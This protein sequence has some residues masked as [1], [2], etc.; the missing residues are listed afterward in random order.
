MVPVTSDV[1]RD[2]ALTAF[3]ERTGP[4][5]RRAVVARYGFEVGRDAAA[6]AVA[7]AV[8]NWERLSGMANPVGYLYRVAQTSARR[9]RRWGRPDIVVP[10]PASHVV[11]VDLQRALMRLRH[12]QRVA[13]LLVHGFGYRYRDVAELLDTTPANVTNHVNRGLARL[14][15]LMEDR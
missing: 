5:L 15:T 6:D 3:V 1:A 4:V 12:E 8:A 11:D 10:E 14:R 13:V 2:D 7:W 9:Q